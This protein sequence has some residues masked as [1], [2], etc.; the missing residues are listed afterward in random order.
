M[1]DVRRLRVLREVAACGSFSA[2]AESLSFTQSAVSQQV[3]AL[4]RECATKLLERGPRGVRLTDAGRAL[5]DHADAILA[6]IEDAEQELAAIAGLRG[7]RLR[8]A[9]FQS[10]G[11][12]IV[13]RA[14]G[15]FHSRH[16]EVEL[17]VKLEE[18]DARGIL[19][20]GEADLAIVM[21]FPHTPLLAPDL[22]LT[23]LLEDP[24]DVI[25]PDDHPLAARTE[26]A[27]AELVEERFVVHPYGMGCRE[28]TVAA[29]R[30]EGFEPKVAIECD[31][32]D[33]V[34]AFVG[35]GLGVGVYPRLALANVRPG[36]AVR[37]VA[38]EVPTRRIF[39]ATLA[40]SYRSPATEAMIGILVDVAAEFAETNR[41]AV[42]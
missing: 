4:E 36:V 21:D 15:E 1:L 29:C 12:T 37:P 20:A 10:A 40:E 28:G 25:L 38:G 41:A 33:Q 5:V 39:A 13:P 11:A 7:G 18:E 14:L 32:N 8:L 23:P 6:R 42:A 3:A 17:I 35:T 30:A 31:E 26:V 2:A 34:Q 9:T 24:Y 19:Q 27:L 22:E 16:P